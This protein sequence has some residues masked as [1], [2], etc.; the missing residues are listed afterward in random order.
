MS[1]IHFSTVFKALDVFV[2]KH[3]AFSDNLSSR[4]RQPVIA[5]AREIIRIYGA[6]LF[7]ASK[8]TCFDTTSIPPLKTNNVQLAKISR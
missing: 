2:D 5:T 7:K 1:I 3:N 4:L 6:S 8:E